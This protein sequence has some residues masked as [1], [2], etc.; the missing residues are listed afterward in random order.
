MLSLT[1]VQMMTLFLS[2]ADSIR[3]RDGVNL[4]KKSLDQGPAGNWD[5]GSQGT[6]ELAGG[7]SKS[8]GAL[9]GPHLL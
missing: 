8:N 1:S 2:R 9:N 5:T 6:L 3:Q 4:I 7:R